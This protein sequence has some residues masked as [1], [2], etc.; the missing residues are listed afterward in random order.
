[1][2]K[3]LIFIILPVALLPEN[4]HCEP[5]L[6]RAQKHV[7]SEPSAANP[8]RL[9]ES[10]TDYYV[11]NAQGQAVETTTVEV[12][13]SKLRMSVTYADGR[14]VRELT[15]QLSGSEW[16]PTKLRER[17]YDPQT[18]AVTSNVETY[19]VDGRE[20]AGN[21]YRREIQRDDL[22]NVTQVIVSV[23]YQGAYDP[24]QKIIIDGNSIRFSELTASGA[25]QTST[26]YTNVVW[27]RTDGQIVS[28]DD[29][30]SGNNRLASA[31]LENPNGETPY[32][33]YDITATYGQ[34]NDFDCTLTGLFQGIENSIVKRE[35][36]ENADGQGTTYTMT[37]TYDVAG[38]EEPAECYRE[39][40]KVD[41]WGLETLYQESAWLEGE[42]DEEIYLERETDVTY[43]P[44]VGYPL[45][46]YTAEDGMPIMQ[47]EFSDYVDCSQS[48]AIKEI[49]NHFPDK[50]FNLKG[51]PVRPTHKGLKLSG[52]HKLI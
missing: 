8:N 7:V 48:G 1:M 37:T 6:W 12:D 28:I 16:K 14:N 27:E 49:H 40:L 44:T 29:L 11:Y 42:N 46:A 5:P 18:G 50:Y 41:R 13:G 26:V 19:Y 2:L 47:V 10:F 32:Y 52:N 20:M 38:S 31:H 34:G 15:E 25:W 24:T 43:D 22:G 35:Y 39:T 4:A 9:V 51:Q 3:K 17:T 21:C 30:F 33:D 36:R 45:S 23:L